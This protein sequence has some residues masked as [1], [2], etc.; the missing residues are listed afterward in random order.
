MNFTPLVE[1]DSVSMV[2]QLL[3]VQWFICDNNSKMND[4]ILDQILTCIDLIN[5]STR[6]KYLS[7]VN[8]F[9][10]FLGLNGRICDEENQAELK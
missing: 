9:G 5:G 2:P 3:S 7:S 4:C 8:V 6:I 1:D 10:G